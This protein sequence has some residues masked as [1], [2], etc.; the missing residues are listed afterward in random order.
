VLSLYLVL[1]AGRIRAGILALV[2][3]GRREQARYVEDTVVRI[4]GGYLRGQLLMALSIGVLAGG[5]AALFGLRYPVVI[6]VLAGV[7]ELIPM[8]G[9]VLGAIPALLLALEHP[10]PT[11]LWV[12]LYFVAIQQLES[13]V[14]GPRITGHAVGLHP[15]GAL[16][17]LLGGFELAGVLGGLFAVPVVGVLWVLGSALYRRLRHGEAAPVTARP[18][19]GIPFGSRSGRAA[20]R[21]APAAPTTAPPL[22]N[23]T[24]SGQPERPAAFEPAT[25]VPDVAAT[26]RKGE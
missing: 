17:A 26:Y 4:A 23:G 10:F 12:A 2:P 6:G 16:L 24:G 18:G 11:V 5:G 1:D 15:I 3:A 13:N 21:P 8:F 22:A 19:W 9:P 20:G 7:F 14:L 25:T